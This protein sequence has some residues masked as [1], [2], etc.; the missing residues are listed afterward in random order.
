MQFLKQAL[1]KFFLMKMCLKAVCLHIL[2]YK[3]V[4]VSGVCLELAFFI[5]H[6]ILLN[7]LIKSLAP[8]LR[9]K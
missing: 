8:T 3:I 4:I 7:M 5:S 1:N 9:K 6:C 2:L